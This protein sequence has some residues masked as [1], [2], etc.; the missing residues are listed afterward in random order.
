M[1]QRAAARVVLCIVRRDHRSMT[2]ALRELHWFPIAQ[3]IEFKVL[4][5]MP[6]AVHNGTPQYLSDRI[7]T[8]YSS[9]HPSFGKPVARCCS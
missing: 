2:A 1:V 3:R 7:S 9:A 4:T 5:L 8:L 6:G